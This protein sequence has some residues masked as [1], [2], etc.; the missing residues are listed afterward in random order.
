MN[1]DF[2]NSKR[3][4]FNKSGESIHL[5]DTIEKMKYHINDNNSAI[6]ICQ[7]STNNNN[8]KIEEVKKDLETKTKEIEKDID[9]QGW[10][11]P[12][13]MITIMTTIL[14]SSL[15]MFCHLNLRI[16]KIDDSAERICRIIETLSLHVNGDD[17]PQLPDCLP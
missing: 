5:L 16:D 2:P 9:Q 12:T 1:K 13:F 15:I 17:I 14:T 7:R 10:L 6:E 3:R 8:N 11:R 4:L